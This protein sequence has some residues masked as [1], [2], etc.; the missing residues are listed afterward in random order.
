VKRSRSEHRSNTS[1]N[2]ENGFPSPYP[3]LYGR[4]FAVSPSAAR[5][6]ARLEHQY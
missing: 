1:L 6:F 5:V 4:L 2:V 3:E